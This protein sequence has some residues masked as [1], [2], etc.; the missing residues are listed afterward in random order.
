[1][2][3][4]DTA[5]QAYLDSRDGMHAEGFIWITAKNRISGAPE[6]VGIWTGGYPT[7]LVIDGVTRNYDGAG[8]LL[9]IED[10]SS[11][12]GVSVRNIQVR[13]AGMDPS[14]EAAVRLYDSRF[15]P[16]EIHRAIFD[17]EN[18]GMVGE[19]HRVWKGFIDTVDIKTDEVGGSVTCELSLVSNAQLLTRTLAQKKSDDSQRLR[20]SGD[21]FRRYSTLTGQIPLFWGEKK[22]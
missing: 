3:T 7:A 10:M 12:I 2:R 14:V 11:D 1:M 13:L 15:A 17:L 9:E 19:P 21:R 20:S 4:F 6:S 5:T 22:V 8:G 18:E 16:V